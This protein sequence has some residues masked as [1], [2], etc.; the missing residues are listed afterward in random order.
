MPLAMRR[1]AALLEREGHTS[2]RI[3]AKVEGALLALSVGIVSTVKPG[4]Q[5]WVIEDLVGLVYGGHLALGCFLTQTLR[6]GLIWVKLLG[7]FTV[8]RLDLAAVGIVRDA[9]DLVVVLVLA[10]LEC[11]LGLLEKRRDYSV[12]VLVM[13]KGLLKCP[14]CVLV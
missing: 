14:H 9:E 13:I 10:P 11:N 4:A 1:S 7:E 5:L 12:L 8:G 2:K 3:A 6:D